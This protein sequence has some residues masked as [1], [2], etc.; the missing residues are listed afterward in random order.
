MF[1]GPSCGAPCHARRCFGTGAKMKQRKK[2][3]LTPEN[4]VAD[5]CAY[6]KV[7]YRKTTITT[8]YLGIWAFLTELAI[9]LA[10]MHSAR[11]ML[12]PAIALIPLLLCRFWLAYQRRKACRTIRAGGYSVTSEKLTSID[13]KYNFGTGREV[14]TR[15]YSYFFG[16]EEYRLPFGQY[17]W[18]SPDELSYYER[19]STPEIGDEFWVAR[20]RETEEIGAVYPKKYFDYET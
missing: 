5:L 20:D 14:D 7:R 10:V 17:T 6:A 12:A 1:Q 2:I 9:I 8:L 18:L 16:G 3:K 15:S 19:D 13:K 11:I 4:L